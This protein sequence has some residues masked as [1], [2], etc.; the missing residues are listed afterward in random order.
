MTT[1]RTIEGISY[2]SG[3]SDVNG[4]LIA[5]QAINSYIQDRPWIPLIEAAIEGR[6]FVPGGLLCKS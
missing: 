3:G 4:K 5:T 2:H 6:V 1:P